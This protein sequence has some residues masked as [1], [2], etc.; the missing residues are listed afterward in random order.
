MADRLLYECMACHAE[1]S[2][3]ECG[4]AKCPKCGTT[5]VTRI[6]DTGRHG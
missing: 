3:T 6:S 2:P 5:A 1:F 4:T